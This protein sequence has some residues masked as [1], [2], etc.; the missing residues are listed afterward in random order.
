MWKTWPGSKDAGL[1]FANRSPRQALHAA[2]LLVLR[3]CAAFSEDQLQMQQ[4]S[5]FS[6][7][8]P[9]L[10]EVH[11]ILTQSPRCLS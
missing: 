5:W 11:Q 3:W 4:K 10:A 8:G 1:S 6:P 7:N 2:R 9:G